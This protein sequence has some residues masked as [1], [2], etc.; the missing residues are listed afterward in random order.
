MHHVPGYK[1]GSCYYVRH[2][3]RQYTMNIIGEQTQKLYANAN[4][5]FPF[6]TLRQTDWLVL[7]CG[8]R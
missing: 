8:T 5:A 7:I 1:P 4:T 6:F 2:V 3:D